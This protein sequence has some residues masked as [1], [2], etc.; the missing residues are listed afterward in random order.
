MF[1]E[2]FA[3]FVL[4]L[5]LTTLTYLLVWDILI[6]IINGAILYVLW[7]RMYHDWKQRKKQEFLLA[8]IVSLFITYL[9]GWLIPVLWQLTVFGIIMYCILLL[10]RKR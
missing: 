10:M 7:L 8:G 3:L 5:F 4:I 6:T 2:L 1:V 9:I